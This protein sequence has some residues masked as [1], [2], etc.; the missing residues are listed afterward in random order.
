[1][2]VKYLPQMVDQ[3]R[4]RHLFVAIDRA[5]RRVFIR[6]FNAKT[7]ANA[8]RFLRGL[9]RACPI[10]IRSILTDNG[11][12]FTDRLFGLRKRA[13]GEHQ[14]DQLRAIP[15]TSSTASQRR[16]HCFRPGEE[17][18]ANPNAVSGYTTS[19]FPNHPWDPPLQAMKEWYRVN[20]QLF[21]KQPYY[22]AGCDI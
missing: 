10:R 17:M 8:H 18:G 20:P 19:S 16:S 2:D 7:A 21:I 15:S 6:V 1:M 11:K 9:E 4:R 13:T 22:L 12:A 3:D 5:T 14:F